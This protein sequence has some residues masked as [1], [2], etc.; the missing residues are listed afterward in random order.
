MKNPRTP[1]IRSKSILLSLLRRLA[2]FQTRRSSTETASAEVILK[3]HPLVPEPGSS[4]SFMVPS[5]LILI[6]HK[7]SKFQI[8]ITAH[9]HFQSKPPSEYINEMPKHRGDHI[10]AHSPS[11]CLP[12]LD[13]EMRSR[14]LRPAFEPPFLR[15]SSRSRALGKF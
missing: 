13:R 7:P 10:T 15:S 2:K 1:P 5:S 12:T 4:P 6:Q 14:D 3:K 8:T 11:F 9:N